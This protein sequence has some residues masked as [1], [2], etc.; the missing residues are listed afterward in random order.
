MNAKVI[1]RRISDPQLRRCGSSGSKRDASGIVRRR[2]TA[3]MAESFGMV[4]RVS[5]LAGCHWLPSVIPIPCAEWALLPKE[6]AGCG[7]RETRSS[8]T[9]EGVV[10]NRDP[11]SD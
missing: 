11:Y 2:A 5:S 10:S 8:G 7:M 4:C 1:R 6:R 3:R 9:V